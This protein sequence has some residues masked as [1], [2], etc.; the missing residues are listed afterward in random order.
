MATQS[1]RLLKHAQNRVQREWGNSYRLLGSRVLRAL[2]AEEILALAATQDEDGVSA[3]K[4][5]EIV[6]EGWL[7]IMSEEV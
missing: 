7:A 4:V 6:T 3:E 2:L 5:R 1:E